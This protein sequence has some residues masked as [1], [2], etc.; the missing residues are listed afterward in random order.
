MLTVDLQNIA[1]ELGEPSPITLGM[2]GK[3]EPGTLGPV[4]QITWLD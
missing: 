4:V 2:Y 1:A 3:M